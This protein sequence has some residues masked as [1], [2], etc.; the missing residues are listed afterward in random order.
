MAETYEI[1]CSSS[2]EVSLLIT[3]VCWLSRS[4]KKSF[5]NLF[6]HSSGMCACFTFQYSS[7][8]WHSVAEI[9]QKSYPYYSYHTT[10]DRT[11]F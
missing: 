5:T 10:F 9:P 11:H 3:T 6:K 2:M 4:F 1:W 7:Q 8:L